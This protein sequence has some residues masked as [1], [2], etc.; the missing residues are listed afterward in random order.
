MSIPPVK[1]GSP[2]M[3]V[4]NWMVPIDDTHTIRIS[5]IAAQMTTPQGDADLQAYFKGCETYNPADHHDDLFAG[6]Y[7]EDP[8]IRLT[9][10]QDY[11]ALI[12]QGAI[13]DRASERLG[14]SDRG[15]AMLRR[16]LWREMEAIN[17]G[18][19][20]KQWQRIKE[21]PVLYQSVEAASQAKV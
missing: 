9:S 17:A 19:P 14:T 13:V 20:T 18:L 8:L 7:P 5:L 15:V 2:W 12:G 3:E 1:A 10:A 6:K 11:V 21:S 16:I 4:S